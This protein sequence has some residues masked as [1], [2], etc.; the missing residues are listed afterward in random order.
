LTC[1][2]EQSGTENTGTPHTEKVRVV[3]AAAGVF[4]K[5]FVFNR[6]AVCSTENSCLGRV[7]WGGGLANSKG[8]SGVEEPRHC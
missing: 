4:H 2:S 8:N 5:I 3:A 7:G 6:L 1:F